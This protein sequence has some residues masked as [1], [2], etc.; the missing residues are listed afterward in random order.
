MPEFSLLFVALLGVGGIVVAGVGYLA[1]IGARAIFRD[2]RQTA[3]EAGHREG[4]ARLRAVLRMVVW[5]LFFGI[6]Y[7]FL[8]FIG[9]RIGWWAALPALAGLAGI[10]WGVLQADRLLT[11]R[12]G[13]VRQ[14]VGIAATLTCLIAGFVSIIWFAALG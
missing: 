3:R 4:A 7:F 9:R 8:F 14:Q 1:F 13:A 11:V 6:Y 12:P 10:I 5:A 2:S